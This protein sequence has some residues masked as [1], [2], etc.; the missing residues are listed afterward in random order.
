ME[1]NA[2]EAEFC[3]ILSGGEE[4]DYEAAR[5]SDEGQEGAVKATD[6]FDCIMK[7]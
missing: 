7:E 6:I 4:G 3:Q 1:L 5:Q 2:W